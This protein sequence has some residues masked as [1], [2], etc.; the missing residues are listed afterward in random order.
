[1]AEKKI[2]TPKGS[3]EEQI[4]SRLRNLTMVDLDGLP[5]GPHPNVKQAGAKS[6]GTKPT[7]KPGKG[8]RWG[9]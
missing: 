1:M 5:V 7:S 3:H 6:K 8:P 9:K 2:S 4:L